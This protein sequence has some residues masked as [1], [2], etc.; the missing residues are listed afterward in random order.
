MGDP[1]LGAKYKGVGSRSKHYAICSRN[2]S[3]HAYEASPSSRSVTLDHVFPSG[4]VARYSGRRFVEEGLYASTIAPD[5]TLIAQ[6][7]ESGFSNGVAAAS[8]QVKPPS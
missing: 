4:D 6:T 3:I 5:G 1:P 2:M 8:V 7:F